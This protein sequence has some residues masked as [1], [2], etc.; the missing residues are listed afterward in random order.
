MTKASCNITV[1]FSS[2]AN[3]AVIFR[4]GPSLYTQMLVWDLSNDQILSGQWLKGRI[5]DTRITDDANYVAISVMCYP[6]VKARE[7]GYLPYWIAVSHPPYFTAVGLWDNLPVGPQSSITNEE[8]MKNI[9]LPARALKI[10]EALKNWEIDLKGWEPR[11]E[12]AQGEK[13]F[14]SYNSFPVG[15]KVTFSKNTA[16]GTLVQ[17]VEHSPVD[18]KIRVVAQFLDGKGIVRHT[19]EGNDRLWW[20]DI[21]AKKRIVYADKGCLWA[22]ANFPEGEPQLIADLNGNTF[23]EVAPPAW[24]LAP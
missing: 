11:F 4:R 2:E 24:A 16:I 9:P 18:Y 8:N 7:F 6:R 17:V 5:L 15:E 13:H 1:C 14:K 20:A 19:M 12:S 10:G 22:W 3:K 21:D 23:E